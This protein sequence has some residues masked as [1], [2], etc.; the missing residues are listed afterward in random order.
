MAA[1]AAEGNNE[2][3][4]GTAIRDG[5]T[6]V[7]SHLSN[8][9]G[10]LYEV[11]DF[12]KEKHQ[13]EKEYARNLEMLV[14]KHSL[15]LD[16]KARELSVGASAPPTPDPEVVISS[17]MQSWTEILSKTETIA[18]ERATYSE[19][20]LTEIA[21][22]LKS[23]FYKKEE[24][25]KKHLQFASKITTDR[26]RIL[27][28]KDK[29]KQA[30]D[31]SCEAVEAAKLRHEK[32]DEK[33]AE[34]LK[35]AWNQAIVDMNNAKNAYLLSIAAANAAKKSFYLSEMPFV[36]DE[37]QDLEE[38]RIENIKTL[39][40]EYLRL[41]LVTTQQ[42]QT[43]IQNLQGVVTKINP[44]EDTSLFIGVNKHEWHEPSD[45]AFEPTGLWRDTGDMITDDY[46]KIVL[47]NSHGKLLKK[48]AD[49]SNEITAKTK[50]IEA[51]EKLMDAYKKNTSLGE[52]EDVKEHLLDG[53]RHIS[54]CQTAK[55]RYESQI[56][57]IVA[58]I[59]DDS[60]NQ[61]RHDFRPTSFALPA[62]CESC[63]TKIWG[64]SKQGLVCKDCGY[65]CH[66]KCEMK[67]PPN[68]SSGPR[69]HSKV[70]S[71]ALDLSNYTVTSGSAPSSSSS[72][73]TDTPTLSTTP[74]K[75]NILSS[76][77]NT[78]LITESPRQ[79]TIETNSVSRVKSTISKSESETPDSTATPLKPY[80]IP[81]LSLLSP[82]SPTSLTFDFASKKTTV[83]YDYVPAADRT[84][85]LNVAAGDVVEIL[86]SDDGSGWLKVKN[87]KGEEGLI[88][89]S[90]CEMG[91]GEGGASSNKEN[92]S[93][94]TSAE[95]GS[96]VRAL[97]SY[98]AQTEVELTIQ[99]GD[100]IEITSKD[101]GDGWWEG[102]LNGKVGQFPASYVGDS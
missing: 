78:T 45:F 81:S 96:K 63:Q 40:G 42:T 2:L 46:C 43:H 71:S 82:I 65:T 38:R 47:Q 56:S 74:K 98:T 58:A 11:R 4:F 14:K 61:K 92:T 69:P 53:L 29:A 87:K 28:E 10:F 17:L 49:V 100:E 48:R 89:A 26:D 93:G 21:D 79:T 64:L 5:L 19:N 22:K 57:T 99:E 55:S 7:N 12:V 95:P 15:K 73:S 36:L 83:L 34:K 41:E 91:E 37:M 77:L 76:K 59:G 24:A 3:T 60:A 88:P 35:K 102:K 72:S 23:T 33:S 25:R 97:Y 13:I 6:I 94:P 8:G 1:P 51:V 44:K 80:S 62:S 54:T 67:V 84:D 101:C 16:K 90:Y 66:Q 68:C 52:Y 75:S 30:Y 70:G 27:T 39:L 31:E 86:E 85:E 20:L 9:L 50:E 32:A 18:K